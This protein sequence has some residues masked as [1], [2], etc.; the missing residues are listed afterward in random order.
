MPTLFHRADRGGA[1]SQ[2]TKTRR[3]MNAQRDVFC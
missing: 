2:K 3:V 1:R